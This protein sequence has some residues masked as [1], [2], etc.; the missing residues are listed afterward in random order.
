MLKRSGATILAMLYLVTVTGFALSLHYCC[1]QLASVK[2]N[3]P[4]KSANETVFSKNKC[5][6]DKRL[7][8]KVKDVHQGESPSFFARIFAFELPKFPFADFFLSSQQ[9][10]SFRVAD[11][12]PPDQPFDNIVTF[13]K[14]CT[15][16]I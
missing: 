13:L 2:I 11:R 1:S 5:C 9:A 12:A 15:F 4:V 3:S 6:A 10:L 16:R 14:N 7:E 8:V